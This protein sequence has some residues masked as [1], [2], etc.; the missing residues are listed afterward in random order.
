LGFLP[1]AGDG[2]SG[3]ISCASLK[4]AVRGSPVGVVAG[5]VGAIFCASLKLLARV[6][7]A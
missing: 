6:S 2:S 5:V 1:F 7:P 4:L 3:A